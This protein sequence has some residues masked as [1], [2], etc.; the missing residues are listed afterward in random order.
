[1]LD[2]VSVYTGKKKKRGKGGG[3]AVSR[4]TLSNQNCQIVQVLYEI[5]IYLQ[6]VCYS[7]LIYCL[8]VPSNLWV[9]TQMM[10]YPWY[11]AK[12]RTHHRRVHFPGRWWDPVRSKEKGT[13]SLEHF[14]SNNTQ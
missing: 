5:P 1:M 12:L 13:F 7:D 4:L 6:P 10:T 8:D 2:A 14:L 3:Y 9:S 11:V